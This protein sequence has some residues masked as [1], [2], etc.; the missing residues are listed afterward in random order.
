MDVDPPK[1]EEAAP[2]EAEKSAAAAAAT[3]EQEEDDE[4]PITDL[5]DLLD[6]ADSSTL[7]STAKIPL[8]TSILTESQNRYGPKASS[9]K[10]RA[11]YGLARAY[12]GAEQY[13]QVV[14]LLTGDTCRGF[15]DNATKAKCAKVV[16]AVLDIVCGLAPE[17]LDMVSACI[18]FSVVVKKRHPYRM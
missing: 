4:E 11:I 3:P 12:C 18:V 5:L 14:Q 6:Q 8:L 15:F 2:A 13:D 10:E 1:A 9:A 16:R 7:S 17:Q